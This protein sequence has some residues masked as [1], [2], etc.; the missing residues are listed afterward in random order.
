[1]YPN[2][3]KNCTDVV[4]VEICPYGSDCRHLTWLGSFDKRRLEDVCHYF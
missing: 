4:T 1:M 2:L 3:C